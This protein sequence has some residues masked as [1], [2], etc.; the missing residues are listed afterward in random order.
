[1]F[2]DIGSIKS[3]SRYTITF[4]RETMSWQSRL[5][6]WEV[7]STIDIEYILATETTNEHLWMKKNP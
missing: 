3:T 5:Q 1:M 6:K 2:G 4:A 7:I